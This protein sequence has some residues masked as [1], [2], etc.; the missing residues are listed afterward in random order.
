MA[1][2]SGAGGRRANKNVYKGAGT[3]TLSEPVARPQIPEL[4]PVDWSGGSDALPPPEDDG[5]D[6]EAL[7]AQV[8]QMG[9][10]SKK[11]K[12]KKKEPKAAA[13]PAA[14]SLATTPI[15]L[16]FAS[17]YPE[18]WQPVLAEHFPSKVGG[19]PVWLPPQAPA[20]S[21]LACGECGKPLRFLMQLYCPRP[22]LPHAYHRSLA[23]LCCGGACLRSGRGWRALR[24]NL[25]EATP[26]STADAS[27]GGYRAH[28]RTE[29]AAADAAAGPPPLPELLLTIDME[30]DWAKWVPDADADADELS[31]ADALLKRYRDEEA[32]LGASGAAEPSAEEAAA[33][34]GDDDGDDGGSSSGVAAEALGFD[35][36]FSRALELG[37]ISEAAL[38]ALTDR[39]AAGASEADLMREH[40]ALAPTAGSGAGATADAAEGDDDDCL[41]AFQR[42]VSAHPEQVVRYCHGPAAS[43]L[44]LAARGRA[45]PAP[46]CPRCGAPRWFEFQIL[47]QLLGAIEPEADGGGGGDGAA[48]AN[49]L[50][51]SAGSLDWGTACVYTCSASCAGADGGEYAEEY[52]WHQAL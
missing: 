19:A 51:P 33:A 6:L 4:F 10:P 16:G 14:P 45:P 20:A 12:P 41:R 23:L 22:E 47:P 29:A 24:S 7:L 21:A 35:A 8:E 48:A 43:P 40:A 1:W 46:P 38:D 3:V 39:V 9:A 30:G 17:P 50:A 31:K 13:A 42:R 44:W 28:G 27:G 18:E 25:P 52:V 34:W 5:A 37:T 26:H 49:P 36:Y 15:H 32:A 11:T 2:V